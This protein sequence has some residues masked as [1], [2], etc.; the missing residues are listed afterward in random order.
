MPIGDFFLY[1]V[2]ST[3]LFLL[4]WYQKEIDQEFQ[5]GIDDEPTAEVTKSNSDKLKQR[6]LV[7]QGKL[8]EYDKPEVP[9]L[10]FSFCII[11]EQIDWSFLRAEM[12]R[13]IDF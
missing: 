1:S 6:K 2:F 9:K 8:G 12:T 4:F 3:L 5:R 11:L 13:K 7:Q 10:F